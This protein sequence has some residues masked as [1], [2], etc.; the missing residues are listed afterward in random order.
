MVPEKVKYLDKALSLRWW[1]MLIIKSSL[2]WTQLAADDSKRQNFLTLL[3]R[4]SNKS[5]NCQG[6]SVTEN[7]ARNTY[8][9]WIIH[10]QPY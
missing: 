1:V 4:C 5:Y 6:K 8:N 10:S 3:L 2:K 9:L 7:S